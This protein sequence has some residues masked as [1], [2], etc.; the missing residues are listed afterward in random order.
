MWLQWIHL[1]SPGYLP[2]LKSVTL[3]SSRKFLLPCNEVIY[4][5]FW[6][7][8]CGNARDWVGRESRGIILSTIEHLKGEDHFLFS[9]NP[10][11]LNTVSFSKG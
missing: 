10:E 11:K 3:T 4:A 2:N 6:R 8:G 9:Q 7:L 1:D 5:Q